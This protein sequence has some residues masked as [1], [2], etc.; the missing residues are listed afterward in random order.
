MKEVLKIRTENLWENI[1]YEL[2]PS[3]DVLLKV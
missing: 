2:F 1:Y 3:I